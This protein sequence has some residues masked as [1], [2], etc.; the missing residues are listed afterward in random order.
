M[1]SLI[2][3]LGKMM[4]VEKGWREKREVKYPKKNALSLLFHRHLPISLMDT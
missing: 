1:I 4:M 3:I 2:A